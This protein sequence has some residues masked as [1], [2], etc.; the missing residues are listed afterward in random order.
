MEFTKQLRLAG[1]FDPT[2]PISKKEICNLIFSFKKILNGYNFYI[3]TIN[4]DVQTQNCTTS[5]DEKEFAKFYSDSQGYEHLFIWFRINDKMSFSVS[6]EN[7]NNI[8]LL[9][10]SS[11]ITEAQAEDILKEVAEYIQNNTAT[12]YNKENNSANYVIVERSEKSD[13]ERK[14]FYKKGV[15]WTAV[16]SVATAVGVIIALIQFFK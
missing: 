14:P 15:F 4:I 6:I 13:E 10:R 16:A 11:I 7:N 1:A 5:Y 9:F 12:A 8:R 2:K 3:S